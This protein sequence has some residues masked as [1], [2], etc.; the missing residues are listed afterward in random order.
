[1]QY[2]Q[3]RLVWWVFL[4]LTCGFLVT[5]QAQIY[6]WTDSAGVVHFSDKSVP[7]AEPIQLP[8]VQE[9]SVPKAST[10]PSET[11]TANAGNQPAT[12]GSDEV[13]TE[14]TVSISKP[15][16]QETVRNNDGD[17]P[18]LVQVDPELGRSHFVQMVVDGKPLGAP[19]PNTVFTLQDA[20]R[21][22]HTLMAQ[23]IDDGG[24]VL[25]ASEVT[26]FYL[27]RPRVGMVPQT[28]TRPNS[29]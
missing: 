26:T 18:I 13:A 2:H 22:S 1:M 25:A 10:P 24:T 29:P 6:K 23:V 12:E 5:A 20:D 14:Y 27:Q 9:I 19:Q 8:Q 15:Q 28:R 17:V 3:R 4:S 21:G 11:S 16:N 7:G